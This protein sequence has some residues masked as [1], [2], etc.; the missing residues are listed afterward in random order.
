LIVFWEAKVKRWWNEKQYQFIGGYEL[1]EMAE[2]E[3]DGWCGQTAQ[4]NSGQ[5]LQQ[6][7]IGLLA[8]V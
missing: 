7:T 8:A 1:A 6:V 5:R 3:A 4:R 2:D